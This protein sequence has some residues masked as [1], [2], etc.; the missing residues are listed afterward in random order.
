M[1]LVREIEELAGNAAPLQRRERTQPLRHGDAVIVV[2]MHHQH[3]HPPILDVVQRIEFL[4]VL[5][6]FELRAAVFVF[7]EPQLLGGVIH[8]A[9]IEHAVVVD[10][11]LPRLVPYAGHPVDHVA[12]IARAQRAS[13]VAVEI[14]ELFQRRGPAFLQIFQRPVTPVLRDRVGEGL[15][16]AD[17]AVEVDRDH[18][19][20]GARIGL[21]VPA[22]MEFVGPRALRT[23]MD[24]E[25]DRIF[26]AG[27]GP[28]RRH[29]V[30]VH[31][32]AVPAL[33]GEP[34]RPGKLDVGKTRCIEMRDLREIPAL[35]SQRVQIGRMREIL[36]RGNDPAAGHIEAQH[37][38]VTQQFRRLAARDIDRVQR[39]VAV[40]R[41][42]G[43]QRLA[44]RGKLQR[45][46]RTI[47]VRIDFTRGAGREIQCHDPETV[48]FETRHL[49]CEVIQR[50]AVVRGQREGV[51]RLVRGGQ[52]FRR[53]G[54]VGRDR[55]HVEVG[56]PRLGLARDAHVEIHRPAVGRPRV[57]GVVAIGLRRHVA[58][59][60]FCH[61]HRLG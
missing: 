16:V 3:R 31:G 58:I 14:R 1:V 33:E 49:H 52:V 6:V 50:L 8:H 57:I 12:A 23:A 45:P 17:R 10:E 15:A 41:D 4:V 44:V 11:A 26:P 7:L 55:I 51:P 2:G 36:A 29:H 25:C 54:S 43:V 30:T 22:V 59:D 53:G 61:Q 60:A 46:G 40:V 28:N 47:P 32:V 13:I 24:Q 34:R 27:L 21:R 35:H 56:G 5:R 42:G 38:A 20:T 18:R 37:A 9:R 48:G 39:D 19:E